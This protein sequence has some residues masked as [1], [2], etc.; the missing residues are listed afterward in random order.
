M[1]DSDVNSETVEC[2]AEVLL[3][4][5][6]EFSKDNR[7]TT[8]DAMSALF[9]V[10]VQSAMASPNYAPALLIQQVDAAI[11]EAVNIQ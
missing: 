2:L 4:A 6:D 9:N 7:L 10:M 5:I 3:A 1:T 11:R 8:G